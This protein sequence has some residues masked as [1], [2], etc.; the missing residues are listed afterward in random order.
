LPKQNLPMEVWQEAAVKHSRNPMLCP[1]LA[2]VFLTLMVVAGSV[3][4]YRSIDR[5]IEAQHAVEAANLAR[6]DIETIVP[7]VEYFD[8]L[9]H[10]YLQ[11]RSAETLLQA[12]ALT[13]AIQLSALQLSSGFT[14]GGDRRQLITCVHDILTI[15]EITPLP[16]VASLEQPRQACDATLLRMR[17]RQRA[18]WMERKA[19]LRGEIHSLRLGGI[20]FAFC[21]VVV[22]IGLLVWLA[23]N[24]LLQQRA[25][26]RFSA[27]NEKWATAILV[28][29]RHALEMKL[30]SDARDQLQMCVC[31]QDAYRVSAQFISQLLFE[32]SGA[33]CMID[34]SRQMIELQCA[35]GGNCDIPEVF[36][37]D[38][39][40]GLRTGQIRWRT[41]ETSV[42]NC[43]HFIGTPPSRYVCLPLAAHSD[44]LGVLYI[45][46]GSEQAASL[47]ERNLDPLSALLQLASMTIAGLNLRGKLENQ[48]IRD[49]LTGLFNRRFM[50]I[51]LERELR[52]ASR[53]QAS[54]AVFM[55]DADHFKQFN[56]TFGHK[57]G[58]TVLRE[59]ADRF[60]STV[61]GEDVV[62]RYGGEEFIIILPDIGAEKAVQRAESIRES[63]AALRLADHGQSLGPVTISIGVA[64]YPG[65]GR[66]MEQILQAADRRLYAAKNNGRNQV[67]FAGQAAQ[68]PIAAR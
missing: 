40:C 19:E 46:C 61:R 68:M 65:D 35:W 22:M 2:G 18:V 15:T 53:K 55:I 52:R 17:D 5:L 32:S 39:C 56:D 43:G 36:P 48:S 4:F 49:S 33:L 44:T 10:V 25:F 13:G 26:L 24:S 45:Q 1:A 41:P 54:L 8:S 20:L 50:E 62:C 66:D 38:A 27:A 7:Q 37:M 11:T 31:A 30:L 23:R 12:R 34:N 21:A 3:S 58:D 28:L 42:V 14:W 64:V 67:V 9:M 6:I 29:D 16:D 57:A 59:I 51:A 60:L 63:V 47:V